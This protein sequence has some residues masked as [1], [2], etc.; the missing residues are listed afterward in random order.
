MD[1]QMIP[2]YE[3]HVTSTSTAYDE[4]EDEYGW[5]EMSPREGTLAWALE[6]AD[7]YQGEETPVIVFDK[8]VSGKTLKVGDSNGNGYGGGCSNSVIFAL[9]EGAS[10]VTLSRFSIA[11]DASFYFDG[12]VTI[13][14]GIK[15]GADFEIEGTL[16]LNQTSV[17]GAIT[18]GSDARIEGEGIT[19][20][21]S[22]PLTI[23]AGD[24]S[25]PWD[26]DINA[27]LEQAL[28]NASYEITAKNP[29]FALNIYGGF[30]SDTTIDNDWAASMIPD[31]F[32]DLELDLTV[33]HG[34]TVTIS[35]GTTL[36]T[37][38]NGLYVDNGT[39]NIEKGVK[40][41][42]A[43]DGGGLYAHV[44]YDGVLNI[45]GANLKDAYLVFNEGEAN[46]SNCRTDDTC[47]QLGTADV[48]FTNCDLADVEFIVME[49]YGDTG[50][51][52]FSNVDWGTSDVNAVMKKFT[53]DASYWDEESYEYV[54]K[55]VP[56]PA[57]YFIYEGNES[58]LAFIDLGPEYNV[59]K[60]LPAPSL[61]NLKAE[62]Y[63]SPYD[64]PG[65]AYVTFSWKGTDG[66][67]Y[68][69]YI[70]GELQELDNPYASTHTLYLSDNGG[71][72]FTYK[73]TAKQGGLAEKEA[74]FS[75][76][77][78]PPEEVIMDE[79]SAVN[80]QG[81]GKV[82]LKWNPSEEEG[83]T[84][85]VYVFGED[86]YMGDSE[87]KPVYSGKKAECTL[88]LK[89]G[90]YNY[91]IVAV[92]KAGNASV[93]SYNEFH[94][95]TTAPELTVM[96]PYIEYFTEEVE[97]E[98]VTKGRASLCVYETN[99][100]EALTYKVTLNGKEYP[101]LGV[102]YDGDGI[103]D[104]VDA[105]DF[106]VLEDGNYKYTVTAT[107]ECNNVSQKYS[108]SFTID[109]T[110]TIAPGAPILKSIKTKKKGDGK[111]DL[112]L[113]WSAPLDPMDESGKKTDR[114]A[115]YEVYLYSHEGDY[116]TELNTTSTSYTFKGLDEGSTYE[117]Y[118][119]AYDKA[120]H[121]SDEG[122]EGSLNLTVTVD[123]EA[124]VITL[125]EADTTQSDGDKVWT[126]FNWTCTD[127]YPDELTF[128]IKI[129][130]KSI[131][132]EDWQITSYDDDVYCFDYY[133]DFLKGG[134]HSYTITAM[135]ASGNS[136]TTK[137]G[138]FET[139]SVKLGKPTLSDDEDYEDGAGYMR[140][141]LTWSALKDDDA[142]YSLWVDGMEIPSE[143]YLREGNTFTTSEI[144]LSDG[145]HSYRVIVTDGEGNVGAI[146]GTFTYDNSNPVVYLTTVDTV[147]DVERPKTSNGKAEVTLSWQAPDEEDT[148]TRYTV[149]LDGKKVYSG[150]KTECKV[151]LEHGEHSY[152]VTAEDKAGNSATTEEEHFYLDAMTEVNL[153]APTVA[154]GEGPTN[155][156][157]DATL[158]WFGEEGSTYVITV[159]GKSTETYELVH[160]NGSEVI[161]SLTLEGLA[162]GKYSYTITATDICGNV[163]ETKKDSFTVDSTDTAAPP[164]PADIKLSTKKTGE[165]AS[166][167]TLKWSGEKGCSYVLSVYGAGY[168]EQ[169]YVKGTSHTIKGLADGYYSYSITA[170][171]KAGRTD[172]L[173]ETGGSFRVDTIAPEISG[174]THEVHNGE[175]GSKQSG[176][177]L[178]WEAEPS[179]DAVT[180][181][182]KISGKTYTFSLN[183][184]TGEYETALK[185]GKETYNYPLSR[186]GDLLVC[187]VPDYFK[188]GVHSYSVTAVDAAGNKKE[189]KGIEAAVTDTTAPGKPSLSKPV[190]ESKDGMA[191]TTLTW[192]GEEGASYKL[193]LDDKVY[194]IIASE[195][196]C[197][198]VCEQGAGNGD[199]FETEEV[200]VTISNKGK[201][202]DCTLLL[203][204]GMEHSY[205]VQAMD[206]AGNTDAEK[207]LAV[208]KT[209]THDATAPAVALAGG[210]LNK[211][212]TSKANVTFVWAGGE[213]T[214]ITYRLVDK[215]T[216]KQLYKGSSTSC[217]IDVSEGVHTYELIATDKAGNST[218]LTNSI[219]CNPTSMVPEEV[220]A[221]MGGM[222]TEPAD[223]LILW[224]ESDTDGFSDSLNSTGSAIY[225]FD[226]DAPYSSG[227]SM[228]T[229]NL[230]PA[231]GKLNINLYDEMGNHIGA[232]QAT[233][234]T[235]L[236]QQLQLSE[237]TYYMEVTGSPLADY[238]LDFDIMNPGES[239]KQ[240][241]L[242]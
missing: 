162:D 155:G 209:F 201:T 86:D 126:T 29:T 58:H 68:E 197:Y 22:K 98:Y 136:A 104:D 103:A 139:P 40:V 177:T 2:P 207:S 74:S 55:Y 187:N 62:I 206:A 35:E 180:Y 167:A 65:F 208:G 203:A 19:F 200:S 114:I 153:S 75:F 214:G 79:D 240:G 163:S 1:E 190:T 194:Y 105:L 211:L 112:T 210:V 160:Q 226:I 72:E 173:S 147:E 107:D 183:E 6:Q 50:S 116:Y 14:E 108:G 142:T 47:M 46:I 97:G 230:K 7:Y 41:T 81:K 151:S 3:F 213:E 10:S 4:I 174:L 238:S 45:N 165:N 15:L 178:S 242:A 11:D 137:E 102:D 157:S 232:A 164:A 67:Y 172:A 52:N 188:D 236:D 53:L 66:A 85:K 25:T 186:E 38:W 80:H 9:G 196:G 70:N 218:T 8:A 122:D 30:E 21:N 146:D 149:M 161:Q 181:I 78:T 134:K 132:L 43:I 20:S 193:T 239:S 158:A 37:G 110:D 217:K 234:G 119:T 191:L 145:E 129:D 168:S 140:A 44:G 185:S 150:T 121:S 141:V 101:G 235:A 76:D 34:E 133:H 123:T 106:G 241:M 175:T 99:G 212:T 152:T 33:C 73:V 96:H 117:I 63:R 27:L 130:G 222:L 69:L 205:S 28:G 192:T 128:D 32:S 171:D 48:T 221:W 220:L 215:D 93:P 71:A 184:E 179:S 61:S 36:K 57:N 166:T 111:A 144:S 88:K 216:G 224:D 223:N 17:S 56:L 125:L 31:G 189:F 143:A 16:Y 92:D 87:P 60:S 90:Y 82:T 131:P 84:Y 42:D 77:A 26:G 227:P 202:I 148:G 176:I 95:D 12:D 195:D 159:K 18:L 39:L 115:S 24:Y 154:Y 233:P 100:E 5:V 113:S 229:I 135:D 199:M 219:M 138:S 94:I 54:E 169:F 228:A 118:I 51:V 64:E 198:T 13:G 91:E 156:G 182:V 59:L 170:I 89:D 225:S 120:G 204:D 23:T 109:S 124:P 83:V 231:D 49:D 237:G 127:A